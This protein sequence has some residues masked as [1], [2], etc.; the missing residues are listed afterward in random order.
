VG[1]AEALSRA[2]D[3]LLRKAEDAMRKA[4]VRALNRTAD[5]VLSRANREVSKDLGLKQKDSRAGFRRE[6][7]TEAKPEALVIATGKRIP[8]IDFAAR[9]VRRGVSYRIGVQGR[10]TLFGAFIATMRSGHRGVFKRRGRERLPIDE[11]LGPSIPK[12]F[13]N[14]RVQAVLKE[15]I[16]SRLV[17]EMRAQARYY[18]GRIGITIQ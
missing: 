2:P 1:V 5:T 10:K 15:V 12:S 14:K 3:V 16:A 7:A 9:Q 4:R 13:I 8:L 6:R 11:R 18:A 17:T